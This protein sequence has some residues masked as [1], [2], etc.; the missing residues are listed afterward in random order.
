MPYAKLSGGQTEST[1]TVPRWRFDCDFDCDLTMILTVILIVID[2]DFDCD[3][4][5]EG[6]AHVHGPCR[7]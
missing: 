2:C 6:C 7:S 3:S 4:D 1:E 5:E